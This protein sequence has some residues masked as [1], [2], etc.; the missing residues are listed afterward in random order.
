MGEDTLQR[1]RCSGTAFHL[2]PVTSRYR[3]RG[4]ENSGFAH[5]I[6]VVG[7]EEATRAPSGL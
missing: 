7:D 3:V 2:G 1:G 4:S 5:W 6:G